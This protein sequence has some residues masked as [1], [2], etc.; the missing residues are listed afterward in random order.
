[1]QPNRNRFFGT[2]SSNLCSPDRFWFRF[3][4]IIRNKKPTGTSSSQFQ[5]VFS[6]LIICKNQNQNRSGEHKLEPVVPKK[7]VPVQLHSQFFPV[8]AT[9]LQNTSCGCNYLLLL[10]PHSESLF[11]ILITLSHC[12]TA[13]TTTMTL[14]RPK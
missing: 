2:A 8:P 1:M 5:L 4:H 7:L 9:G 3:L 6:F 11:P 13:A 14:Q 12:L 10:I